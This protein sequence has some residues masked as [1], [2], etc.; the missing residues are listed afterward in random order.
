MNAKRCICLATAGFIMVVTA[1]GALP[2]PSFVYYGEVIDEYGWPVTSD[3]EAYVI[4]RVEGRECAR[5]LLHEGRGP[6]INYRI[7]VPVDDGNAGLYVPHAARPG[8]VV[9]LTVLMDGVEYDAMDPNTIPAVGAPGDMVRLNLCTGV[10]GDGDGLPDA[11]E[12]WI[13]AW[14]GGTASNITEVLGSDDTDGD[15]MS[16]RD[17]FLAGTD[18]AWDGDVLRIE[19]ISRDPSQNRVGIAFYS[20]PGKTYRVRHGHTVSATS[21]IGDV[22]PNANGSDAQS[23]WR[24]DGYYS[25][26]YMEAGT[27]A[28]AFIQIQVE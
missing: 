9:T 17:E 3:A 22:T 5:A 21:V 23:Y 20:I 10:D 25:W 14:G 4:A 27:N 11:L 19:A 12:N 24:G 28:A 2:V 26:L 6:A 16:N 13:I 8:D 1:F 15:G 7:E 18:P